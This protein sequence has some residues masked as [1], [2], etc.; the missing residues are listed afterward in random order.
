[1]SHNKATTDPGKELHLYSRIGMHNEKRLSF[2]NSDGSDYDFTGV[3]LEIGVKKNR[4]DADFITLSEGDGI[5]ITDNDVDFIFTEAQS[6]LFKE[7]PY[8]WQLRR[9]ISGNEKVWLN[10]DHDWHNGKFDAF[11]NNGE[12]ITIDDNGTPVLITISEAGISQAELDA[13]LALKA[14]FNTRTVSATT[15]TILTPNVD[16]YDMAVLTAQASALTIANPTGT[17]VNGNVFVVRIKDNGTARAL[18]FGDKYRA[19]G[20]ALPTTTTISKTLYF[21]FAYNSADEK[22]DVFPSQLEV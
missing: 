19:I 8:Y 9:T 13:A 18:T 7:R 5:T 17:P 12:T 10:G 3:T 6:E 22:Y 2:F 20:S 16:S 1:V 21:A 15:A 4:G 11:N 14:D